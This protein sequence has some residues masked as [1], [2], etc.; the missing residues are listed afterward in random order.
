MGGGR[1]RRTLIFRAIDALVLALDGLVE[2]VISDD[3]GPGRVIAGEDRRVPGTGLGRRVA[4]IAVAE[5]G[6]RSEPGKAGT[7]LRPIFVEQVRRELV[8]R[9]DDEELRRRW[10][11]GGGLRA[12]Q[13]RSGG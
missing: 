9:D 3:A 1:A 5:I 11:L 4:L 6:P 8:D 7:E 13:R 12:Q 10:G 2:P